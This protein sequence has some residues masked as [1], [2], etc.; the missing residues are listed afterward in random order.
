MVNLSGLINKEQVLA[1]E[2]TE[3]QMAHSEKIGII[4][5]H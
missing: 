1:L 3:L 4:I 5:Y 2:N